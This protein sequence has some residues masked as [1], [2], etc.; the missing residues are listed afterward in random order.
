MAESEPFLKR[1][2]TPIQTLMTL[3]L[4][5]QLSVLGG[6]AAAPG[7]WVYQQVER[8]SAGWSEW[9]RMFA[10]GFGGFMGY[11]TFTLCVLLV[12][13]LFRLITFAGTPL[14]TYPYYSMK[15]FQ[16]ASYNA[17]ILLVRYTCINWIRVTPFIVIFHRLMGMKIGKRVQINTAVIGD[18]NLIEIGDDTVI[19]GDCTLIGHSAERGNLVTSRVKIGSNVTVGLM[20]MIMPGV[21]IGDRAVIAANAFLPKGTRVEA[22]EIWA[23]IPAK[24]VGDRKPRGA[25]T[26]SSSTSTSSSVAGPT[27]DPAPLVTGRPG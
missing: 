16:W 6:L 14:G 18:S 12:T 19:G 2:A 23:G 5:V 27:D 21:E 4:F 15:G 20:A 1:F 24:K 26:E 7:I 25:P 8:F 10:Q 13:G 3:G 9:P 11:F 17:I 22:G